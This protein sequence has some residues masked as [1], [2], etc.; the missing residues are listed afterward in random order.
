MNPL[1]NMAKNFIKFDV[2]AGNV[3][4]NSSIPG[5]KTPLN[6]DSIKEWNKEK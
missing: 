5:L 3:V 6:S 4:T 2:V 1:C